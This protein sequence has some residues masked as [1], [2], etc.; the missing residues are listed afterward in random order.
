MSC[1]SPRLHPF[2]VPCS[3]QPTVMKTEPTPD[4]HQTSSVSRTTSQTQAAPDPA[5]PGVCLLLSESA[6]TAAT[7]R[8][9][10]HLQLVLLV[11]LVVALLTLVGGLPGRRRR[12]GAGGVL[13]EL[14]RRG[15]RG[16]G[17]RGGGG[18]EAGGL[19]GGR[20]VWFVGCWLWDGRFGGKG[21]V[22]GSSLRVLME[23][24]RCSVVF[25]AEDS[26]H[27]VICV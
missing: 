18:V 19:L 24:K 7:A 16:A 5:Y 12:H 27:L 3:C 26:T 8:Q 25:S 11:L 2:V 13:F 20:H 6:T 1:P 17:Q 4:S 10:R 15:A 22:K 23:R 9:P 14:G 21:E